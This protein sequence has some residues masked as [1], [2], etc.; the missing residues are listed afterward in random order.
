M[1]MRAWAAVGLALSVGCGGGDPE[2]ISSDAFLEDYPAAYCQL[3]QTCYPERFNDLFDADMQSCLE[4]ARQPVERALG[5]G[6]C[7]FDGVLAAECVAWVDGL[8]CE[9]WEANEEDTCSTRTI[10]GE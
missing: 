9:S 6:S 1:V 3:Q 10:C 8:D 5:D 4:T 7:D 2:S